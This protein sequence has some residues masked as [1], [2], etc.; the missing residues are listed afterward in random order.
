M[1]AAARQ[2]PMAMANGCCGVVA[3]GL[4]LCARLDIKV[5]V[6][7]K[8]C[9]IWRPTPRPPQ[10]AVVPTDAFILSCHHPC[11]PSR[12]MNTRCPTQGHEHTTGVDLPQPE[13]PFAY[14]TAALFPLLWSLPNCSRVYFSVQPLC[15]VFSSSNRV[16][17]SSNHSAA[18]IKHILSSIFLLKSKCESIGTAATSGDAK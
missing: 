4:H 9:R 6:W 1:A 2:A 10:P 15:L 14:Y 5:H 13:R 11:S 16:W 3:C 8:H 18:R 7:S 17:A 12:L